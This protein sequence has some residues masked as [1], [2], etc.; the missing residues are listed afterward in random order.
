MS[1]C[2]MDDS[3]LLFV[4]LQSQNGTLS[5]L[6]SS[7]TVVNNLASTI[8]ISSLN[9]NSVYN[10]TILSNNSLGIAF[11]ESQQFCKLIKICIT[12]SLSH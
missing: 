7:Q 8:T 9:I 1:D 6:S 4:L 10:L 11:S 3:N 2:Q 5:T 12:L